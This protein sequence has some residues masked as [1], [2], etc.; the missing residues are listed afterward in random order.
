MTYRIISKDNW[1]Q[2][3]QN[4]I[5]VTRVV[6]V[7]EK[8]KGFFVFD[9]LTDAE[10]LRLDYD[11]TT[12]P[13]RKYFQPPRETLLRFTTS[14]KAT[15]EQTVDPNPFVLIGI[16]PYDLKALNQMDKIFSKDHADIDYLR[17][18]EAAT[19]I[20]CDPQRISSWAFWCSMDAATVDEGYDLFVT[21]IVDYYLIEI[22]S[23]KG[24]ALLET[25]AQFRDATKEEIAKR[26]HLRSEFHKLCNPERA[27]NIGPKDI[28]ELVFNNHDHP[29]WEEKAQ[30]CYSCG[31]CNQVCPT[32]YCFDVRDEMDL[33]MQGGTRTRF[34][35]GC[36][37][38][39]FAVV[40]GGENFRDN[41][42]DRFRHRIMRKSK[43]VPQMID[44]DLA[45][46]GCGR[47]SSQC[48]PDIADPLKIYN[49]MAEG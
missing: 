35:D 24:Q 36:L 12:L 43:Y 39:D 4:L 49:E 45:C 8:E 26:E 11:V 31:T 33:D 34:W 14:P 47:C 18:R 7:Q 25:H 16:H 22:G 3:V 44:S 6:G 40:G 21:D 15:V 5:G 19:V 27:V 46:V 23:E 29:L 13:P 20:A 30:K 32:C 9:E 17:R 48:L 10:R 38:K 1:K 2:S 42:T 28:P 41:R 37:L